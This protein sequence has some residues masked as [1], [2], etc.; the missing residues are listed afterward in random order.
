MVLLNYFGYGSTRKE[1]LKD[2]Y[3][4]VQ[5]LVNQ[6]CSGVMPESINY[7]LDK[8]I[9]ALRKLKPTEEDYNDY[10]NE[11]ISYIKEDAQ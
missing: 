8:V 9:N 5:A 7:N 3:K 10:I 4:E 2:R 1:L 11:I 6:I